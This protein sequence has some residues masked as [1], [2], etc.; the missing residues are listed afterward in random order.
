MHEN[1]ARACWQGQQS[2]PNCKIWY[3]APSVF[4]A[5]AAGASCSGWRAN[6]K[7]ECHEKTKPAEAGLV[8]DELTSRFG[9][10]IL[11]QSS[12]L[13]FVFFFMGFKYRIS[14]RVKKR[15]RFHFPLGYKYPKVFKAKAA[16]TFRYNSF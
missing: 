4:S 14:I 2:Y 15:D 13:L 16:K 5:D 12:A 6:C 10:E 3:R 11:I 1:A 8:I 7:P 9:L